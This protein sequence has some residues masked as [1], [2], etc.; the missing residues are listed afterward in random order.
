MILHLN[1]S[2][3]VAAIALLCASAPAWAAEQASNNSNEAGNALAAE[4]A[5]DN[6][7]A[8]DASA[9][10]GSVARAG[11]ASA[12]EN[13][14][15]IDKLTEAN[16]NKVYY[17]TELRDMAGKEVVHRWEHNG[18]VMAEVPFKVGG[19]RWRVYSSKRMLPEW[20]GEWKAS[21]VGTD[22]TVLSVNTMQLN[23]VPEI[24]SAQDTANEAAPAEVDTTPGLIE[25]P[26]DGAA[27]Q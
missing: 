14:E 21:V 9:S 26:A 7:Q 19:D 8:A 27:Q 11:F 22:G 23:D 20:K 2:A 16:A 17:F 6:S 4:Q 5:A 10:D 12:I 24:E 15:P 13:R 3:R 18:K 25:S 1:Q